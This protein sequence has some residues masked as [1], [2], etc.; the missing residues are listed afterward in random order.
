MG[1]F[2]SLTTWALGRSPFEDELIETSGNGEHS[3]HGQRYDEHGH[4]T[5]P[6][7]RRREREQVRAAN[8]VMQ[9][10]GVVEDG[11]AVK[12]KMKAMVYEKNQETITGFRIMEAGRAMLVVGVWGVLGFRRR[13]LLYRS[14]ATMGF[15]E[16]VK[17]EASISS[18]PRLI[19]AGIPT[20][21]AYHVSDWAC[22][23]LYSLMDENLEENRLTPRQARI[24]LYSQR[25]LDVAFC[26]ITLHFR[27][28]A[29]L[30]QLHLT[31][32]SK[33]LPPL[34]SFIPFTSSSP[35]Q[36][37][38]PPLSL[39]A[40]SLLSWSGSL[41]RTFAPLLAIFIH[42][43]T[44]FFVAR[45]LYGPVYRSLPRPVGESMFSGLPFPSPAGE[46]DSPDRDQPPPTGRSE[47]E[48]TLRALEGLPP[49][50]PV[51]TE[52]HV[53]ITD[54]E[55]DSSIDED[56]ELTHTT[57]ISFDVEATE[58]IETSLGTWSAELRSA[59]EPKPTNGTQY[60][61]TGLTMLS[62]ILAAEGLREILASMVVLP[63]EAA[64]VRVVG[65]AFKA[66]TGAESSNFYTPGNGIHGAGNLFGA[67]AV[68]LV[69]TGAVWAGMTMTTQ[70]MIKKRK[71]NSESWK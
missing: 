24:K 55:T 67:F 65:K 39:N 35:L 63:L 16:L 69:V 45:M 9:V 61:I 62:P 10:T 2:E 34:K 50:T 3:N 38:P 27:I 28:Y 68:Q 5:N 64:M 54:L 60:R 21:F 17:H 18:I 15:V 53:R 52:P 47:D 46:Y 37:P 59:N 22:F 4:P 8:E 40:G 32:A 29:M 36:L 66:R 33:Y 7:T 44:K 56:G 41:F 20:V 23:V 70:W 43:K 26:Y 12:A 49:S 42:G 57:L 19:F 6:N 48:A 1:R 58:S 25:L 14:H 30:Q 71:E 13:I 31:T 51:E 11:A